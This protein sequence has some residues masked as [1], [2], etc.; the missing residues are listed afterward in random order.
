MSNGKGSETRK[1]NSEKYG[2]NYDK[3]FRKPAPKPKPVT[4]TKRAPNQNWT[5]LVRMSGLIEWVDDRG[6]GHPD[7]ESAKAVAK[8]YG[9]SIKH[10]LTHGCNGR[11]SA[12]NFPGNK[13]EK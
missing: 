9:H 7:Y 1:T 13:K 8:K 4:R 3:I 11:C 10:W 12:K 5:R 6:V 2:K